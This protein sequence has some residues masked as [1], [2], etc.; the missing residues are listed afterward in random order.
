MSCSID[1][2]TVSPRDSEVRRSYPTLGQDSQQPN[3]HI[4]SV[5]E[6]GCHRKECGHGA[7]DLCNEAIKKGP[8]YKGCLALPLPIQW[9]EVL[10]E[11]GFQSVLQC[12]LHE[13]TLS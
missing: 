7:G 6:W 1:P 5:T 13:V 11:G 10:P 3:F 2:K 9:Q 4:R 12:E 8:R